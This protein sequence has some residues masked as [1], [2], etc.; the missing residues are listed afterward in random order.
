FRVVRDGGRAWHLQ[1][2]V[3][4]G[5]VLFEH[6]TP[7][8]Y[9][10]GSGTL[11]FSYLTESNGYLYQTPISWYSE[12]KI[13]DLSPGFAPSIFLGRPVLPGS[14]QC[15]VTRVKTR[16]GETSRFGP[17]VFEGHAIGCERCHGPGERHAEFRQHRDPGL[18]GELDVTIVNPAR[19][20]PAL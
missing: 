2:A 14:P 15:H 19:L 7:V 8:H 4:D 6:R 12:K 20:A 10:V 11:A 9:A 1:S 17:G 3:R 13:W 18:L 16:P 5:E